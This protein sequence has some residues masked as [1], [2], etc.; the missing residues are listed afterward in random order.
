[1]HLVRERNK[2]NSS[3]EAAEVMQEGENPNKT[4]A[5]EEADSFPPAELTGSCPSH[6]GTRLLSREDSKVCARKGTK[7]G[8]GG[9]LLKARQ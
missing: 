6:P 2:Q 4:K 3:L 1:M 9:D 5:Y 7:E 8:Q